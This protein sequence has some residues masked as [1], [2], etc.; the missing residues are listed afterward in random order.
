[1]LLLTQPK[2][3]AGLEDPFQ[4][5]QFYNSHAVNEAGSSVIFDMEIQVFCYHS[6]T[7]KLSW[8][9]QDCSA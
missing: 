7:V 1:M 3:G 4:S 8:G 2:Q 9:K 6:V 5:K